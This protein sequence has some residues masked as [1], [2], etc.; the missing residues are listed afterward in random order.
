MKNPK[1]LLEG[2][3]TH[4][5]VTIKVKGYRQFV[6][7]EVKLRWIALKVAK[8]ELNPK[9]LTITEN[10]GTTLGIEHSG[11]LTRI[12]NS[13]I[14]CAAPHLNLE[15]TRIERA[16]FKENPPEWYKKIKAMNC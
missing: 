6:A 15:L 3:P 16:K 9:D 11:R 7:D 5:K 14:Y 1:E 10:D 8:G 2:C 12:L 4:D 13:N